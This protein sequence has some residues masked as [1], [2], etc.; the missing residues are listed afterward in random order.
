MNYKQYFYE[1]DISQSR[2]KTAEDFGV[3]VAT[4]NGW[5][6]K[7]DIPKTAKKMIDQWIIIQ[8]INSDLHIRTKELEEIKEKIK[9]LNSI[10]SYFNNI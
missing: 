8:N 4:I 7:E 6:L 3:S 2:D 5:A 10:M 9:G 1:L